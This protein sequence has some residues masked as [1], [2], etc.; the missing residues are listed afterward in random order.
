[1]E[2]LNTLSD[3]ELIHR[4]Q[5][6]EHTL[7]ELI[8]RR[9]NAA[10]YK[11]GRS[12]GL[13][14]EDTEDM[15]QESF[16]SAY[17]SL[18]KFEHRSQFKTWLIR[19]MIHQC[20][21]KI[22]RASYQNEQTMTIPDQA[23]PLYNISETSVL[24]QIVQIELRHVIESALLQ[25]PETYR[26][27]FAL[28]EITGLSTADTAIALNISEANVKVRLNRAKLHLRKNIEQQYSP[29]ELFEFNLTYCDKMLSRVLRQIEQIED[30]R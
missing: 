30:S 3:A 23:K 2:L 14:H 13:S 18:P 5:N 9:Y 12:Y 15:M 22:H 28:R 17:K 27:V 7:F 21:R 11:T 8:V 4:I 26:M 1:M 29:T 6:G 19:I 20:Y 10:L 24:R 25:L 16:V